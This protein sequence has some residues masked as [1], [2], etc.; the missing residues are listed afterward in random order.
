MGKPALF[1]EGHFYSP[2]VDTDEAGRDR[3]RIWPGFR[4][5]P[6]IDMQE[7]NHRRLLSNDF[8][9]LLEEYV[10]PE[11]GTDDDDLS[12]F[13]QGNSQFGRFD[14]RILFC[15]LRMLRP[16]R[17]IEVGSGFSSLLMGD[18]NERFL[19]GEADITCIEPYPRP[20]LERDARAGRHRLLRQ[21]VQEVHPSL[22]QELGEGDVLFID[23]SHV[24]KT[25]SDVTLLFLD[26]LPRLA[27]GVHVH[28]HDIFLPEDYRQDWVLEENRSWNEQY[29]L[30]AL[31]TENPNFEVVFGARYAFRHLPA[32]VAAATGLEPCSGGS[33]WFRRTRGP[34][35]GRSDRRGWVR[36][37][38]G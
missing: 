2:V 32:L 9:T 29:L 4:D 11:D 17:I 33:F 1:P 10:Y 14:S 38:L 36:R 3:A 5:I 12:V 18:V 23:S 27:P 28:V 19:G 6:G 16:R 35:R 15:M 25:G 30:Q 7:E 34:E 37:L 22:F 21:R 20:F 26:V 31:L 8:P 24:C 13:H